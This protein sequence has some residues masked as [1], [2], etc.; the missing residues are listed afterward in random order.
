MEAATQVASLPG[1]VVFIFIEFLSV[2]HPVKR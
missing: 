2:A 1:N